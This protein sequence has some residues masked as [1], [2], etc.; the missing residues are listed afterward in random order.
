[1]NNIFY[2]IKSQ[3]EKIVQLLSKEANIKAF[4]V[5]INDLNNKVQQK[6]EEITKLKKE[7]TT[8]LETIEKYR[9]LIQ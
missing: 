1:M 5:E 6:D 8:N 3:K 4:E 2:K 9:K 7:I